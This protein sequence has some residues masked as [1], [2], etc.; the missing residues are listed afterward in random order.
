MIVPENRGAHISL[1]G[2]LWNTFDISFAL[3]QTCFCN[4]VKLFF[5]FR[6]FQKII[7]YPRNIFLRFLL[8]LYN[9]LEGQ[10][11][12][13]RIGIKISCGSAIGIIKIRPTVA[14]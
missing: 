11:F 5:F 14:K 9:V 10:F 3:L 6:P 8:Y 13:S 7:S 1:L 12:H 4:K 2:N